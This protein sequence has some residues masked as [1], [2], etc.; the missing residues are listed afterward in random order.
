[1]HTVISKGVLYYWELRFANNW[2]L[3]VCRCLSSLWSLSA[4]W[5]LP[6]EL[7]GILA[8]PGYIFIYICNIV[9]PLLCQLFEYST[10]NTNFPS[11]S[12]CVRGYAIV[13]FM[14]FMPSHNH[15][16]LT[17]TI[18][19]HCR[20]QQQLPTILHCSTHMTRPMK[21]ASYRTYQTYQRILS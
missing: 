21:C 6:V 1:M 14:L 2:P 7:I 13:L 20:I 15:S 3:I 11:R 10:R 17:N 12:V 9:M 18:Q 5:Q 4:C 16:L 8:A 19:H